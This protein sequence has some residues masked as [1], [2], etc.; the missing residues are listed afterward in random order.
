MNLKKNITKLALFL[1]FGLLILS[2]SQCGI[3]RKT[4]SRKIPSNANDRVKKNIEE[5]RRIKFGG[6]GGIGGGTGKFEF[7]TSN[8]LWRA[9]LDV[10]DFVP[11]NN[12]DYG[13]GIVITD[14][15]NN[16]DNNNSSI[17][18]MVQFLSNEIRADGIKVIVYNKSC[19]TVDQVANCKTNT[20]DG[21]VAKEIKLAILK[22]A[23]ILKNTKTK[24]EVKEYRKKRGIT[25]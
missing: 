3:Y 11:L 18:I 14:W 21:E 16:S 13:G 12:A 23:T 6:A 20:S 2:L 19:K 9:T 24:K 4:D 17:K 15:Y 22:E 7:A 5:G 25:N 10:L 8:E 1:S